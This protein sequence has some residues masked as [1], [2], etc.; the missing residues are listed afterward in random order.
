MH[1]AAMFSL[2]VGLLTGGRQYS[3]LV[4][5]GHRRGAADCIS[6]P[7]PPET[8]KPTIGEKESPVLMA[9][10]HAELRSRPFDSSL[11][12]VY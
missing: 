11:V 6:D 9:D 4:P 8:N 2:G 10:T 1:N 3:Y 7:D 12:L 5:G